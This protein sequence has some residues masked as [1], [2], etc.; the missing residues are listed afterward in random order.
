[1]SLPLVDVK[2]SLEVNFSSPYV[3]AQQAVQDFGK[4]PEHQTKAFIFTGNRL[5]VEPIVP[6]MTLGIGKS[7]TANLM[8]FLSKSYQKAGYK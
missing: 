3:A 7:A 6:L 2:E 4:L 5:N 8:A 1:M